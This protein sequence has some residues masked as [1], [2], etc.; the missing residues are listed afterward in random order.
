MAAL[1]PSVRNVRK[2]IDELYS[3]EAYRDKLVGSIIDKVFSD[4][5]ATPEEASDET[6]RQERGRRNQKNRIL[7]DASKAVLSKYREVLEEG[8][9]Q[10]L[11]KDPPVAPTF[12]FLIVVAAV[13]KD[14]LD[15]FDVT[16]VAMPLTYLLSLILIAVLFFWC[17]GK[18]SG[19]W[20]KK[21]IISWLWKRYILVV[22]IELLPGFKLI[23]T[24][25][26]FIL[27]AHYR[28][29]KLVKLL[30]LALEELHKGG[31]QDI[32]K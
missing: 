15:L 8:D 22:I 24:T 9:T 32:I 25:T 31:F 27:M 16:L 18:I 3:D 2:T 4:E 23:P 29:V 5:E 30:N 13:G 12:P 20:W 10:S 14:I 11:I 6:R 28:E 26:I 1:P 21:K 7:R 17:L 19:G